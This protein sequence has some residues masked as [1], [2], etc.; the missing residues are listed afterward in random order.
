[1]MAQTERIYEFFAETDNPSADKAILVA[2]Q[3]AKAPY[4]TAL[5]ELILDRGRPTAVMELIRQYH[6]M[7]P[8]WQHILVR[9]ADCLDGG[10][11]VSCSDSDPQTR[12]NVL[13]LIARCGSLHLTELVV[14]LLRDPISGV[15]RL[16]GRT[17]L[18]LT[19]VFEINEQLGRQQVDGETA[20][21]GSGVAVSSGILN[22]DPGCAQNES[23]A[24]MESQTKAGLGIGDAA[25]R[26]SRVGAESN[27]G[28][29]DDR[30]GQRIFLAALRRAVH[31]YGQH[32]RRKA[33][34][35]G[36]LLVP[37]TDESF[38]ADHLKSY[39]PVSGVVKDILLS[40]CGVELAGFCLSA[41]K[42]TDLRATAAR[43]IA[44][45]RQAGFIIAVA[46]GVAECDDPALRTALK[47][48]RHP[49]WLDRAVL[50]PLQL[51]SDD[52]SVLIDL[53]NASA[54]DPVKAGDYLQRLADKAEEPIALKAARA[55]IE[56]ES[57]SHEHVS[58]LLNG[59]HESVVLMAL[60]EL[61][62]REPAGLSE[63]LI[64]QLTCSHERVREL[65]GRH[66][67]T[68]VYEGYWH[69]FDNLNPTQQ[70]TAGIAAFKVHPR[71]NELW[72]SCFSDRSP[73]NQLRA[74]RIACVLDRVDQCLKQLTHIVGDAGVTVRSCAVAALGYARKAAPTASDELLV[75]A[76]Q[77]TDTRVQANA[78]EA[79]ERRDVRSVDKEIEQFTSSDN[80]RVR[81]NAIKAQLNWRVESA[82]VAIREMLTDDRPNHRRSALWV[83]QQFEEGH[84]EPSSDIATEVGI[85]LNPAVGT[86]VA[87][88][89]N[90]VADVVGVGSAAA[91]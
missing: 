59:R 76:L 74:I 16:A 28:E 47:L 72:L 64:R 65:A 5:F 53:I 70:R 42:Q 9:R 25:S 2:L 78:V 87:V 71:V 37:A 75:A 8:E 31:S 35:C 21:D 1:M 36:M 20:S 45:H 50:E 85:S 66:C 18:G 67:Y 13:T 62:K 60:E 88:A 90:V 77:D 39:W 56:L 32:R 51:H 83:S 19:R 69:R 89:A 4:R 6:S 22:E 40:Q 24:R 80:N 12:V 68:D 26:R 27:I 11:R 54:A 84:E 7:P 52:Q 57:D 73:R 55:V 58:K 43:A 10:L 17:L 82:R 41:L 34:L 15:N 81:A 79:I 33:V 23:G 14:M 48:I 38:W 30:P 3:R 61:I 63:I 49:V 29:T 91:G 86:D 46:H 44:A